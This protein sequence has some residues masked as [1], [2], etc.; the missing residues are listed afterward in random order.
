MIVSRCPGRN[1]MNGLTVFRLGYLSEQ[2]GRHRAKADPAQARSTYTIA[3][4]S[5][6]IPKRLQRLHHLLRR[7]DE[8]QA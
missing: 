4:T 7:Q 5:R 1:T 2:Q 3:V 8:T 6:P